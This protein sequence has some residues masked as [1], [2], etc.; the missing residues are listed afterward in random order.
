MAKRTVTNG[1]VKV[2][3]PRAHRGES[4]SVYVG[5]NGVGY[6]IPRGKEVEVP[7]EVAAELDRAQAAEDKMWEDKEK[8]LAAARG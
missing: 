3:L 5:I 6:L 1:K 8:R 4:E 7:E 2:T